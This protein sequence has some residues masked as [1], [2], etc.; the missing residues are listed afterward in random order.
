M[1]TVIC[2]INSKYI[3]SSLAPWYLAAGVEAYCDKHISA[4]V[5]EGSIN[6]DIDKIANKIIE[7]KPRAI[8]LSCYIW[9]IEVVKALAVIL[10]RA[11]PEA[12]IILGGPEVSFNPD[13]VLRDMPCADFVISGEGEKPFAL[14]LNAIFRGNTAPQIQ[15]V[16]YRKG[17]R[18]FVSKPNTETTDPP[19]PYNDDYFKTLNG[20]IAYLETSRGCPYSCAFCLSGFGKV[21]FFDMERSKKQLLELAG[22]GARTVKLVDRTFNA[23]RKRAYELFEFIITNYG[24]EIPE[25][26]CF[27]FE[28]AGDLLDEKTLSLLNKAP[29]GLIQTEIGIQSFNAKTLAAIKRKTDTQ[30]LKDNIKK[31][32]LKENIH[33]H[34]D[35]IAGLP[36]EDM[37][38]F[39]R[40]FNTAFELK[41][42]M[43]QLGFLKLLHGAAM[44]EKPDRYPCRFNA[45]PPYEV[46]ET[47]WLSPCELEI[48]HNAE[49][50]LERLYNSRRFL[51]TVDYVIKQTGKTPFEFFRQFG[52]YCAEKKIS[53]ISLNDYTAL[54]FDYFSQLRGIDRF[55]LRDVMACDLLSVNRRAGCPRSENKGSIPKVN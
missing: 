20:R 53:G 18:I 6:E 21:R 5:I 23:N 3:H 16:C 35:L 54:A 1:N 49:D 32:L 19:D 22:S 29:P 31:L 47:P 52:S 7:E 34:I 11:L 39:A 13:E 50:S 41:P 42:H 46:T 36:F 40:S 45:S 17:H 48:L 8:G 24:K 12:A 51:M 14:L 33:V 15:G 30:R 28:I 2:A 38:S 4:K 55:L 43:L 37:S 44:R 27:H 26:V 10:K 25:G 9:N